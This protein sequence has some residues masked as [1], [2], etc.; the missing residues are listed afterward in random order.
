[1]KT[2]TRR[3]LKGATRSKTIIANGVAIAGAAIDM[4]ATNGAMLAALGPWGPLGL[5]LVNMVL[6]AA[7]SESLEDKGI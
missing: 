5:A 4:V 3:K 7:T 1:M 6:R 2:A